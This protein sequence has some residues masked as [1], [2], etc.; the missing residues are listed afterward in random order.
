MT[1]I[2]GNLTRGVCARSGLS[3]ASMASHKQRGLRTI[4]RGWRK[5]ARKMRVDAEI[6]L[7]S[8]LKAAG[9]GSLKRAIPLVLQLIAR[10]PRNYLLRFELAQM[11]A[12]IGQ[13]KEALDTL[14]SEIARLKN[15]N[16]LRICA[17]IPW[18][19]IY[20]T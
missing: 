13:R 4:R 19:K 12:S 16:T 9:K 18:E 1:A 3:P 8:A 5:K 10:Y 20:T 15:E 7:C 11:Y 14:W 2:V 17:A 6:V